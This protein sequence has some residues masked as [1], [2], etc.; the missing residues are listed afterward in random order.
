MLDRVGTQPDQ[1]TSGKKSGIRKRTVIGLFL[2]VAKLHII[3]DRSKDLFH[4]FCNIF[5]DIGIRKIEPAVAVCKLGR[6]PLLIV[7]HLVYQTDLTACG[8]CCLSRSCLLSITACQP[9][10]AG[11]GNRCFQICDRL[12]LIKAV[13][14]QLTRSNQLYIDL[15]D[16]LIRVISDIF[17]CQI[18][19]IGICQLTVRI[20]QCR[21]LFLTEYIFIVIIETGL[22][23]YLVFRIGKHKISVNIFL[24]LTL[25]RR[26]PRHHEGYDKFCRHQYCNDYCANHYITLC[27]DV[28]LFFFFLFCTLFS[29]P[30]ST[31]RSRRL[32]RFC[33]CC[34]LFQFFYKFETIG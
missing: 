26:Q 14:H 3:N 24:C 1:R 22:K 25:L 19:T 10:R 20:R 29:R 9:C 23:L 11:L 7:H 34:R 31:R 18:D 13:V 8:R 27:N 16:L 32:C 30:V 33:T 15:L 5:F 21:I 12:R 17:I 28:H 4:I 2:T 6:C